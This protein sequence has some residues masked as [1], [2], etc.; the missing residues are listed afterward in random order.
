MCAMPLPKAFK[1]FP[2]LGEKHFMLSPWIK[3]PERLFDLLEAC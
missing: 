1:A 2:F 3:N